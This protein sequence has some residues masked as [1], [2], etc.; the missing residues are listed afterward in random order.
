MAEAL[1]I[2]RRLRAVWAWRREAVFRRRLFNIGHIMSGNAASSGIGL[3]AVAVTARTLGPTEYGILALIISFSR[4][5]ERLVSFQSWQPMI[6][7]GAGLDPVKDAGALK[8]LFKFGLLIDI[9]AGVAA[10]LVGIGALWIASQWYDWNTTTFE[11]GL[12][13][14]TVLLFNLSGMP[15]AVLRL[16]GRFRVVAYGQVGSAVVRLGLCLAVAHL[17]GGLAAFAMV[18]A[19]TQI[20]GS[21]TLLGSGFWQLRRQGLTGLWRAPIAGITQRF[22]G[23]WRFTWSANLSLTLRSS[24]NQLDT[25]IVGALAGPAA[26]GLYHIAKQVGRIAQQVGTQVQAVIYPDIAKLW[27]AGRRDEFRRAVVQVEVLLVGFGVVGLAV[28]AVVAEPVLRF[29]AG[30]AFAAAAPLLT[31]QMVAVIMIIGGT[32]AYSA[33]LAMGH[34]HRALAVVAVATAVFHCTALLLIPRI[35]AM[36]ANIAHIALGLVWIS[37]LVF[38]LRQALREPADR[39]GEA[40]PSDTPMMGLAE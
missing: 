14:C 11:T 8:S 31:V 26:A 21:L 10:W 29:A 20:L 39:P 7:Y 30:P 38:L 16:A 28:V 9:A 33:L 5:V 40:K 13:Y 22:G 23:L 1:A 6:R 25:L 12:A 18:W 32:A 36:G 17:G 19:A 15:T 37:G 24:A 34:A 27:A 4:A 35:G 2:G 3:F